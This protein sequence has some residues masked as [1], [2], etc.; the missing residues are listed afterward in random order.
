MR[1]RACCCV[2]V[3]VSP[4]VCTSESKT[5]CVSLRNYFCDCEGRVQHMKV[6]CAA[7]CLTECAGDCLLHFL[8]AA[9][10]VE[11]RIK[12]QTGGGKKQDGLCSG[13]RVSNDLTYTQARALNVKYTLL[14]HRHNLGNVTHHCVP[15]VSSSASQDN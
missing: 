5:A 12:T 13:V 14:T 8:C 15:S 7:V 10:L 6:W 11:E 2:C 3:C 4:G 9:D 1:E